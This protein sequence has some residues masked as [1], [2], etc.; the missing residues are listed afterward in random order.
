MS[1]KDEENTPQY[2]SQE[3]FVKVPVLRGSQEIKE[4][5]Y[6]AERPGALICGG[7]VRYMCS[8]RLAPEQASDID[9]YCPSQEVLDLI[10]KEFEKGSRY[11][12]TKRHENDMSITYYKP[13][14]LA[15]PLFASPPIQLIKPVKEGSIVTIGELEEIIANFDFTCIRAGL[16]N[17]DFALVDADFIHDEGKK[18][19][20]LKN[21]H[22]PI[23]ST[24]RCM[25]YSRKGYWLNTVEASK[26]FLDWDNRSNS[27]KER[28]DELI[29]KSE[30]RELTKE[31]IEELETLMRID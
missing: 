1:D 13:K 17:L 25:K 28:L 21:I 6:I 8:P 26:L 29:I 4:V 24:L 16:I 3:G 22:C 23:S 2:E 27:Y 15:H 11:A 14:E 18:K 12:L 5:Y 20:R 9:I 30:G 31:E 10:K 19:L 7:Y